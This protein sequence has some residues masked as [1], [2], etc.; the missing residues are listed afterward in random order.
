MK[1]KNLRAQAR[2]LTSDTPNAPE[3]EKTSGAGVFVPGLRGQ[4]LDHPIAPSQAPD[5]IPNR[6]IYR[7]GLKAQIPPNIPAD[8]PQPNINSLLLSA[9]KQVGTG[10]GMKANKGGIKGQGMLAI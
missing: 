7:G 10:Q 2:V 4:G 5:T 1:P 9:F 6:A 8:T 3:V